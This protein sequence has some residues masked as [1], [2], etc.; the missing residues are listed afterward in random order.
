MDDLYV[1][2]LESQVRDLDRCVAGM[3]HY[4]K[5]A[6]EYKARIPEGA[7][8]TDPGYIEALSRQIEGIQAAL[9]KAAEYEPRRRRGR[10][11]R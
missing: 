7:N 10:R 1:T 8:L 3:R 6:A 9:S 2:E 4:I 11:G 5:V